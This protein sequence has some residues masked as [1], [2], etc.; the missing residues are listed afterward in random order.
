MSMKHKL[1]EASIVYITGNHNDRFDTEKPYMCLCEPPPGLEKTDCSFN[2]AKP[3]VLSDIRGLDYSVEK[4]GFVV[5]KHTSQY[6]A[7]LRSGQTEQSP[8]SYLIA[9]IEEVQDFVRS[10]FKAEQAMCFD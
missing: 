3:A 1:L 7:L 9:Y 2:S 8:S 4:E 5:L 10:D 6:E